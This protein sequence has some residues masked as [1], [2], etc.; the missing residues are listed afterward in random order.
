MKFLLSCFWIAFLLLWQ[1][2]GVGY[3]QVPIHALNDTFTVRTDVPQLFNILMND[4]TTRGYDIVHFTFVTQPKGKAEIKSDRG[5]DK[6]SYTKPEDGNIFIDRFTYKICDS[7]GKCDTASAYIYICPEGNPTFPDV[8][9]QTLG[10]DSV[11]KFTHSGKKLR[12]SFLPKHGS[13]K[14]E[15]DSSGFTYTPV[16]KFTG[17]D[18]IKYDVYEVRNKVCGCI[19][20]EGRNILM[21]VI[22]P[23]DEN[24]APVAVTDEVVIVGPKKTEIKVLENDYDPEGNLRPKI[25]LLESPKT[26][27]IS[28]TPRSITYTPPTGF[29][30]NVRITYSVC[31]YNEACSVGEV[32]IKVKKR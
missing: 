12:L 16:K 17:A 23:D 22:P 20:T 27:K 7:S 31:D 30:G 2:G 6:L 9:V 26:A 32:K 3:A 14:M 10:R 25:K 11:R 19:R 8:L 24:K 29:E 21:Q 4:Y 28:Y 15:A 18:T 5:L 1:S 13:V